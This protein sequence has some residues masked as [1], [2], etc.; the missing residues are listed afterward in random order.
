[1]GANRMRAKHK[2]TTQNVVLITCLNYCHWPSFALCVR[3]NW[4]NGPWAA[5]HISA[6]R[7][8]PDKTFC[9]QVLSPLM[10]LPIGGG[11][12]WFESDRQPCTELYYQFDNNRD[13]S[14][15]WASRRN[16]RIRWSRRRQRRCKTTRLSLIAF[17]RPSISSEIREAVRRRFQPFAN[18]V[19]RT[20][21]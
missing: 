11:P 19:P 18:K 16:L 4:T 6:I 14:F 1:M 21:S 7:A 5:G 3:F 13:A 15:A 20:F 9:A 2:L 12:I 17:M 10:Q 8:K